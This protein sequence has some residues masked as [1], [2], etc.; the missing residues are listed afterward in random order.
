M[1]L[2][3]CSFNEIEIKYESEYYYGIDS[4][5]Y[6]Q[7]LLMKTTLLKLRNFVVGGMAA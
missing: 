6:T 1:S 5:R 7:L 3:S 2:M 4:S